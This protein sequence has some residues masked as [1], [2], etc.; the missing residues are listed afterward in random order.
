MGAIALYALYRMTVRPSVPVDET[1]P[2]APMA[3]IASPVAGTAAQE[4]VIE[5]AEA[6]EEAE[7]AAEEEAVAAETAR[8]AARAPV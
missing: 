3:M 7:A 4:A 1:L 5:R 2:V 6:E 8:A